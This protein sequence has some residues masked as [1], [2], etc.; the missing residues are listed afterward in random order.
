MSKFSALPS[1]NSFL[2]WFYRNHK[3]LTEDT[4]SLLLDMDSFIELLLNSSTKR[5]IVTL[6]PCDHPLTKADTWK[7]PQLTAIQSRQRALQLKE[8]FLKDSLKITDSLERWPRI[9]IQGSLLSGDPQT[10]LASPPEIKRWLIGLTLPHH[11]KFK[12]FSS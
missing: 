10:N 11:L 2:L 4:Y 1:T 3:K 6:A 5:V 12:Q 9:R 7:P 8:E